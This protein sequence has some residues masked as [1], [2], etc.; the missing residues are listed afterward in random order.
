MFDDFWD[1]GG[2]ISRG[3]LSIT[4]GA[5]ANPHVEDGPDTRHEPHR[6]APF[7]IADRQNGGMIYLPFRRWLGML[8]HAAQTIV[9]VRSSPL[10]GTEQW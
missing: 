6:S 10:D 8:K 3:I 5:G 9:L 1:L 4:C 7:T 2:G